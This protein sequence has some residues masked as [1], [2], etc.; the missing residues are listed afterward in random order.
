[1]LAS[2][3][4]CMRI[5]VATESQRLHLALSPYLIEMSMPDSNLNVV[6]NWP[7][8][9]LYVHSSTVSQALLMTVV[10]PPGGVTKTFASGFLQKESLMTGSPQ[11]ARAEA[12]E[13]PN[14]TRSFLQRKDRVSAMAMVEA[15]QA[16]RANTERLEVRILVTSI[17]RNAVSQK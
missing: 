8:P 15:I 3:G 11:M 9:G 14:L 5:I 16:M 17:F 6:M 7:A 13:S 4:S 12:F 10:E 2:G 1:M